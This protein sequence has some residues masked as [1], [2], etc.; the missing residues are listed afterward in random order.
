[1]AERFRQQVG[2]KF[3]FL[4]EGVLAGGVPATRRPWSPGRCAGTG[5]C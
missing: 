4:A 5:G 3:H 2:R 1:V